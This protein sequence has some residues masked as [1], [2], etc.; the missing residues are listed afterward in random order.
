[1]LWNLATG[2]RLP[3]G[4][5]QAA[6]WDLASRCDSEERITRKIGAIAG[7]EPGAAGRLV[8]ESLA[9]WARAGFLVP[10]AGDG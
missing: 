3:L 10:E 7:L 2:A 4:Y 5:P 9:E 1:M 8:R 6:V